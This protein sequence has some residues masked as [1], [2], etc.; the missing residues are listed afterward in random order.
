LIAN[1][2]KR[3]FGLARSLVYLAVKRSR[4]S[5]RKNVTKH[6]KIFAPKYGVRRLKDPV[7]GSYS[8]PGS[9]VERTAAIR[10]AIPDLLRD[11]GCNSMVDAQ[12]G[13]FKWMQEVDLPVEKYIGVD[14]VKELIDANNQTYA[15]AQREFKHVDLVE[16]VLPKA[17][18]VLNR[19]V[20][21]HLSYKDIFRFIARLKQSGCTYL[22]TTH[23]PKQA[24][25][26]DILTG[27]WRPVNLE[28]P[29]FEFP[30]PLRSISEEYTANPEHCDKCLAL[31]RIE[32]IPEPTTPTHKE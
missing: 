24:K 17:D 13:D 27:E 6:E 3:A 8:G 31:W 23:F 11:L 7:H 1:Q 32:D 21:I 28:I 29:P 20:L 10:R 30:K 2:I 16:Q 5:V 4:L 9:T 15:N 25:N 12:C 22:L 14:V 26:R 19:D 18:L